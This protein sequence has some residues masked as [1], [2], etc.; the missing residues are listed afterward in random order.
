MTLNANPG[1]NRPHGGR[2]AQ[3][4]LSGRQEQ[5][6]R[7]PASGRDRRAARAAGPAP[8]GL[9]RIFNYPRYGKGP[10]HR[11]IPSWRFCL[12]S[13]LLMTATVLGLFVY[14][15]STI[16]VPEPSEFAQAQTTTI[17]YSDGVTPMGQFAE[18][19]RT[20]ID[21]STIPSHVGSAVVASE[22]RSFYTNSGVD[23]KG[24]LRALVN[25]ASG[26][27]TQGASTLTQQY[28][29]NYYVDT[30][31]S[32][33]GKFQQAIMALKIDRSKSKAEI[34]GSYL[35][36]VYFGRSAYG[37]EAA[38]QAYFG[39]PA[40]EMT[41]S[42]SAL[43]A[44][45][46]PAPSAWDPAIDKDQATHRWNRVLD[47]ML[48]DGYITQA[49]R[50]SATFPTTIDVTDN[51]TYK[52]PNG[53]LLQMVREELTTKAGL[54]DQQIDTGG[55]SIVT[56][57]NKANQEAAVA[58]AQ[59]LPE[60]HSPNLRVGLV[61][62]DASSGGILSLYGGSDY[63]TG[64][65]NSSTGA[66]AQAGST[67][68]PFALV[69]ALEKGATLANGYPGASPMTID[70]A[71]FVNFGNAQFRWANLVTATAYS[72]NTPYVQLNKD[73]GPETTKEVAKRAGFPEDT[74]GLDDANLQSVLGSASPH[75]IDIATAY[76]TFASQGTR[77]QT[78]I[79]ASVS[80]K[81]VSY[82][83]STSG[84]KV[85]S[86]DVMADATYAMQQV[87]NEGSGT[88]AL[89]LGRPIAAKTG[90][91]SDNKS[92]HFVGYTPQ[93]AT[94]VTL[95]QSGQ[96]GEE[97]SITP[98]GKYS[99]I[100]GSTYPADIFT[101]YMESALNGLPVERFPGRTAGSYTPGSLG[102]IQAPAPS[103]GSSRAPEPVPSLT[104]VEPKQEEDSKQDK[105]EETD[106]EVPPGDQQQGI[107][108]VP[109]GMQT[110][111]PAETGKPPKNGNG[112]NANGQGEN[113]GGNLGGQKRF[114]QGAGGNGNRP[115]GRDW[116]G[117]LG[118]LGWS[119]RHQR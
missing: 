111:E 81:S 89:R 26:G 22:D 113:N 106:S 95:Y 43:L 58:A 8:T 28:I 10:I 16:K 107:S 75:T 97:E 101:T 9:R 67:F 17:Y 5:G 49:E 35:N 19:N 14:A 109:G 41:Y 74:A 6:R 30:T 46:L 102:G 60:G 40:S 39:H 108:P 23:P 112:G 91:S 45:I 87:V 85:F 69:A 34:L 53:Y 86:D 15:Y 61:S 98:W 56:T 2:L 62:I 66:V 93:V 57:I 96:N 63:L 52:G 25:N 92:A 76:A 4:A 64:G 100:T 84:E 105:Q 116:L 3:A 7:A 72:V 99:E 73:V 32:Y 104:P 83:A 33:A 54:T 71:R 24:I 44:G 29:K 18:I 115:L 90:S 36:T 70:G 114:P 88:T 51:E 1:G 78:H 47:L 79:V 48:A 11:W 31:N 117:I 94:A 12:G 68:K 82:T 80:G 42:E 38:S 65:L 119:P 20:I 50:D 27:G 59:S 55:L 118:D 110:S 13:F 21:A 77:H 103:R 37:I